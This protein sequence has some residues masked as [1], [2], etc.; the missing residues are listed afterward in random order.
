MFSF[1]RNKQP[2]RNDLVTSDLYDE[3]TFYEK[4]IA[5]FQNCR[6]ELILESPFIMSHR[7]RILYPIF[8]KLSGKEIKIYIITRNPLEHERE[9]C[10]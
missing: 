7:M 10:F 4:F 5:D 6:S 1:F 3:N 2:I 9:I 8:S